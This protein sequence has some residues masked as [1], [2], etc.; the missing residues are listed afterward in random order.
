[1]TM[2]IPRRDCEGRSLRG[3]ATPRRSWRSKSSAT[4]GLGKPAPLARARTYE[5]GLELGDHRQ[6]V[7]QQ[8]PDRIGRVVD[9]AAEIEPH[10]A[11]GEVVGDVARGW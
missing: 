7:E 11:P 8:P 9:G 5:I 1:M 6:Q 2:E 3:R 10:A 4:H